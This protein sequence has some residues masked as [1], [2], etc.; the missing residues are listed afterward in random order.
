MSLLDKDKTYVRYGRTQKLPTADN[1][2]AEL[3]AAFLRNEIGMSHLRHA[4]KDETSVRGKPLRSASQVLY[5]LVNKVRQNGEALN[6]PAQ[7]KRHRGLGRHKK[8][9]ML[10][11]TICQRPFYVCPSQAQIMKTCGRTMC[12]SQYRSKINKEYY[13]LH[14]GE[15][16][17]RRKL[18]W[19]AA[20]ERIV[21]SAL[22]RKLESISV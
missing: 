13:S 12:K 1:E 21:G 2:Y 14:P 8:G 20:R 7:L 11:C 19:D 4:L 22:I 18:G 5:Y 10:K 16:S 3:L 15:M 17:R 9:F 6:E